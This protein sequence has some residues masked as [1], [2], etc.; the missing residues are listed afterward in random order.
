MR[1]DFYP[2]LYHWLVAHRRLVLLAAGI[3]ALVCVAVSSRISLEEDILATLPQRDRIVDEYK[4]TIRKFHQI[5]RVYIDVGINRDDAATLGSA[6]DQFYAHLATN[7]AFAHITYQIEFG[8]QRKITDFLTGA[9]PNLFTETDAKLLA[10]KLETNSIRNFLTEKRRQLAGPEGMALKDVVAA[11]PI[12]MSA[13]VIAKVVP[14]QTGFGDARVLDG[15]LTSS[16]GRHTLLMAEPKFAS[17]DSKQSKLLV[18]EMLRA[19]HEVE[20]DFP[21]THVAITGGHRMAQDNAALLRS[22]GT[23]CM[24]LALSAM[25]ILCFT[26]YR[27][28]WLAVVTFLPSLFG[29]LIAGTVLVLWTQHVSAIAIGFASMAIGITVDYGIYVVY[30]LDNAAFDRASAGKIVGRLVLPTAIGALTIIAAFTVLA[31]SP[32]EGYQQLGLFGAV[33]VLMAATFALFVLPLLVP[34]PKQPGVP[35]QLRFTHWMENFHAW[36]RRKRPLLLLGVAGMTIVAI[37]GVKHLRFEGDISKLNGITP[38]TKADD[39]LISRTWGD[40]LGMTLVVARGKTVDDALA[41]ND[42]AA[43]LL[44][45]QTNVTGIYSL[46]SV[47]PSMATQ[48]EN[49]KRWQDFWTPRRKDK[50]QQTLQGVGGEL[51][52]R[53]EAF[54]PFWKTVNETPAPITLDMFH[55]TALEEALNER[56]ATGTNDTAISTLIKLADRSKAGELRDALPGFI[57]IDQRNFAEHIAALAK[58]G[59]GHFALWTAIAVG[60]IVYLTLNSIELIIA[61]LLPI[62]FGLLWTLGLMG[63]LGLPINVMNCVFVIFVI[64]MGEDYSVFLATSK[65]DEWRG[66]P[67]R[68]HATSASV[69]ISA[70][71]TIFGFAVLIFARHPVLFSMGTTV[72]LGMIS[73]FIA[74]LVITPACMDLLL[75]RQQP[76]GA[77]RW[78]HPLGTVWVALHLGSAQVFLYYVLRP[79]LKVFSPRTADE[80]LRDA[81]RW[82]ARGVIK[83]VPFGRLEWKNISPATF[84]PPCIVISNHQSAVDVMLTVGLPGDV[85]QTAKKRVFDAPFLGIGCKILGHVMVEPNDPQATL[86]RC[87]ERLAAGASVHF[88]P[89]GTR[90]P[91][92][93]VQRFHRGAFELAV[94]LNQEI[95]PV[96]MCDTWTG[97]PRDAY[98]FEPYHA[99][100]RAIPRVTPQNFDYSLG[101]LALM[102]HCEK[103]VRA[104]LQEQLDALNTPRVLRRKVQRLYRYQGAFT[105]KFV[106]WKLKLDPVFPRLDEVVP[107]SGFILDLGCGY[108]IATH[109]LACATDQ[110]SFLGVDYDENKLRIAQRTAPENPRIRFQTGDILEFVFPKCDVILL[111]DV[112]HYWAPEKQQLILEKAQRALRPGGKLILRDGAK[113]EDQAHQSIHR[114]EIF[115]TKFGLNQTREGLHFQTLAELLAALRNAGF[116]PAEIIK[117]AGRGSNVLLVAGAGAG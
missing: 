101:S 40:A 33:G 76:T 52:F 83:C 61:T 74:T 24:V 86:Q 91:D 35:K 48:E 92:G 11:D 25:F 34:L 65:M 68:I 87:R 36:Q 39:Q 93:F 26:A 94:E 46:A 78:W 12:G 32:M 75:F 4:Y 69:L 21:G 3:I 58:S 10:P 27:R 85:R 113:A 59:M 14:L 50:L 22:D 102:Q 62:G 107:R 42:R 2:P 95:L 88:Y 54:A 28:R 56:V 31:T 45:A 18:T 8:S 80:K 111:L 53:P 41:Q 96:I 98:W 16:D 9:L 64:G 81:T 66:H 19:A 106:H 112:L 73:S 55:G 89:E 49:I 20:T 47:C 60:S 116:G 37:L 99:V 104:A 109:W 84:S 67:P 103:I 5:D 57:L 38:A 110:R 17:S 100:V 114:W 117:E 15:R 115:A 77:P 82:M 72:L 97:V 44:A 79:W 29:T 13:L 6:A 30:H 108:G 23:R 43:A 105:E 1:P 7:A 51:G 70:A 90:S 71:T 63:L